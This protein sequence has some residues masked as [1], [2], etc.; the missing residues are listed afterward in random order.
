MLERNHHLGLLILRL[1]VGGLMLFHGVA[2]LEH[3]IDFIQESVGPLAYGVYLGE[4]LAPLAIVLGYRTRLA[5]LV[6]GINC[7]AAVAIA[8]ST[9]ILKL[10]EYGGYA[11]ELL[12]LYLVGALSL[13][14]TGG[15]ALAVSKNSRWD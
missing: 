9:D 6:F 14:F 8:H 3:G 1:A 10:N 5:A 13:F 4:L 7:I 2:K 15:G 11:L 12:A